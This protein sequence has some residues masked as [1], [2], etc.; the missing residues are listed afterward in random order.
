MDSKQELAHSLFIEAFDGARQ[1]RSEAYK[2]GVKEALL[3]RFA[4][5]KLKHPYT[6]GTAESDAYYAGTDEGNRIYRDY[7]DSDNL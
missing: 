1:P 2:I 6:V 5:E 7:K 3:F 4:G